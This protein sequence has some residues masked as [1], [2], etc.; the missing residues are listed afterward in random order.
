[1]TNWKSRSALRSPLFALVLVA[2]FAGTAVATSPS[3]FV[4]TA[5]S[6]VTMS[7]PLHVNTGAVKFQTKAS[8]DVA[9]A[10]VTVAPGGTSGWHSHP[11]I[12]I[13]SVKTGSITFYDQTC[14]GTVHGAGTAFIEA[15]GDGPGMARNESATE[16]AVLYVT[17]VVPTGAILRHDEDNPGC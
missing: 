4:G 16:S 13:V 11:G 8:V 14:A 3:G 12:V 17:Y 2:V 7:E 10:T 15:A 1:M 5:L 6:R 9:T